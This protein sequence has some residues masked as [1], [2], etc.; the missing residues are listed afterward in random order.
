MFGLKRYKDDFLLGERYKRLRDKKEIQDINHHLNLV[1]NEL[2]RRYETAKNKEKLTEKEEKHLEILKKM[3]GEDLNSAE[4]MMER[5]LL[6]PEDVEKIKEEMA[7]ILQI[8]SIEARERYVLEKIEAIIKDIG[9]LFNDVPE[10][11]TD[12]MAAI[13]RIDRLEQEYFSLQQKSKTLINDEELRERERLAKTTDS[14]KMDEKDELEDVYE[15]EEKKE[16]MDSSL[17]EAG[18]VDDAEAALRDAETTDYYVSKGEDD[19]FNKGEAEPKK[20]GI[21]KRI[22]GKKEQ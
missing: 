7:E 2:V 1:L 21:L 9:G 10:N 11:I 17:K 18:F 4:M 5:G 13:H 22:F 14:K 3:K 15:E 6:L 12:I 16:K 8:E 19:P 20:K